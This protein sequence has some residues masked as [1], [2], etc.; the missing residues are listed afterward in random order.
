MALSLGAAAGPN[1]RAPSSAA[2]AL[3]HVVCWVLR[4]VVAQA[5]R[6]AHICFGMATFWAPMSYVAGLELGTVMSLCCKDCNVNSP[7]VTYHIN[8]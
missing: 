3:F 1:F 4:S 6:T 7:S 2:L 5:V 8:I